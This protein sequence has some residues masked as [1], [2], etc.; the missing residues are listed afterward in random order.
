MCSLL[1]SGLS[2]VG[3]TVDHKSVQTIPAQGQASYNEE[4]NGSS[5][6]AKGVNYLPRYNLYSSEFTT[7]DILNRDFTRFH[8]DGIN[9]ISLSVWWY[10]LEGNT[11]GSYD[12]VNPYL[13]SSSSG[14]V[15]GDRFLDNVK[16]V[17]RIA[18]EHQLK[19]LLTMHTL[20]GEDSPWTLPD[21][22]IDPVTHQKDGMAI[23]RDKNLLD[24]FVNMYNHTVT[25]LAGTPGIWAWAVLNE[26]YMPSCSNA[27][28]KSELKENF[29]EL[30]QRLCT[31]VKTID[32]RP[33][34]I[35][36]LNVLKFQDSDGTIR[37]TNPF[38]AD[39]NFDPR[40]F[41]SL[42]FVG[43]NLYPFNAP[44]KSEL[45]NITFD[46]AQIRKQ[47]MDVASSNINS[48]LQLGKRVWLTELGVNSNDEVLQKE[49][50]AEMLN[51][52]SK[53]QIDGEI[54]WFWRSDDPIRAG[55]GEGCNLC[56]KDSNGSPKQ[57]Y[58]QFILP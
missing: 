48:T 53:L 44:L 16:R 2:G 1:F 30:I 39:W 58:Y 28:L 20:W 35:R 5:I 18:N 7:D 19:V 45:Y 6:T 49:N 25:Y 56:K 50:Y 27:T 31:I 52:L 36:F 42:D 3:S 46:A 13:N 43:F 34:T 55:A 38:K 54:A 15:Y 51:D 57:A 8:N 47:Y 32:G 22:V 24:A 17:I 12:G 26:P 23:V 14:G 21:Y 41:D 9:V 29:V 10:R 11:R 4:S 37:L 40:I 33:A